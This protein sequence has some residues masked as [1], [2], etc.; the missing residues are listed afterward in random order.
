MGTYYEGCVF[1]WGGNL[2]MSMY[3]QEANELSKVFVKVVGWIDFMHI[4][5]NMK[6]I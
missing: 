4:E 5:Y 3:C 6:F 2:E 1:V